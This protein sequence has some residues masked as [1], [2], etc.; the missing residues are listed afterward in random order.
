M[1]FMQSPIA[2]G[3]AN[4]VAAI[5]PASD[6]TVSI[7]AKPKRVVTLEIVPIAVRK[8]SPKQ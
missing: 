6:R 3:I 7:Q 1:K 2:V 5:V 8:A 4:G